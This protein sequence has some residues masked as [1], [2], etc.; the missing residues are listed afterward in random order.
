MLRALDL[1]ILLA[2]SVNASSPLLDIYDYS[3]EFNQIM[4]FHHFL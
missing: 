2:N 4:K 1:D 3:M